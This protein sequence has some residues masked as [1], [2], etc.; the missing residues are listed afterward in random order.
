MPNVGLELTTLRSSNMLYQL[1]QP[2][3]P[4]N[5]SSPD[6]LQTASVSCELQDDGNFTGD[7]VKAGIKKGLLLE[8][9]PAQG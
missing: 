7:G 3:T 8:P 1:S 2:G 9:E 4:L 6:Q 5:S